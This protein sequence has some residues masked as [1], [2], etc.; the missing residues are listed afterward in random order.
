MHYCEDANY[1]HRYFRDAAERTER[2]DRLQRAG[3]PD[4]ARRQYRE[5]ITMLRAGLQMLDADPAWNARVGPAKRR[6]A[7]QQLQR[8]EALCQ[9]EQT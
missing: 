1:G 2:G 3:R 8:L 5:A 6:Q 9:P 7:E 4:H